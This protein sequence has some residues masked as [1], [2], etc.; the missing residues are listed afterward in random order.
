[1]VADVVEAARERVDDPDRAAVRYHQNG[2]VGMPCQQILE[3]TPDTVAERVEGLRV[4]RTSSCPGEP[5]RMLLGEVRLDLRCR[6]PF[7]SAE[8]ALAEALVDVHLEAA[9]V[10]RNDV[11]RFAGAGEIAGVDD[12]DIA[13]LAGDTPGLLAAGIVEL[14][15]GVALPA[16]VAVPVGFAVAYEEEG[17]HRTH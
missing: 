8:R 1:M 2:L 3:E 14:C 12:V 6:P 13:D 4:V 11:R 10:L 5:A 9:E 16:P 15:I 7:P 17:G